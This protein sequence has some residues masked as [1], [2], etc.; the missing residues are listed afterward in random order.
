MFQAWQCLLFI[1]YALEPNILAGLL[2]SGIRLQTFPDES[3]DEK[4][5]LGIVPFLMCDVQQ[6]GLPKV[7]FHANF[8]ELNVRT[9][10]TCDD[11]S[12]PAVWFF[13][14]N[15]PSPITC[16]VARTLYSL[17]YYRAKLRCQID[18]KH[19]SYQANWKVRRVSLQADYKVGSELPA[20]EPGT[21]QYFLAERYAL[22]T[23]SRRGVISS[24]RVYHTPY[25]LRSVQI[26]Q[27]D[28]SYSTKLLGTHP[29]KP[30]HV[31]Y[32]DGVEVDVWGIERT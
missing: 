14:L 13:S 23:R 28:E 9:Y 11:G 6:R 32:S 18:G 2:P 4:A 29:G 24:G 31:C 26:E 21:L 12:I 20:S 3:G 25:P 5:W 10:V 19:V 27:F 15:A 8:P 1:H 17:P 16:W 30:A 22:L 7:P